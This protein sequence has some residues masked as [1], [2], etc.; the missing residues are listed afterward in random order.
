MSKE[1]L[2]CLRV[3]FPP[4]HYEDSRIA[5]VVDF[6][7]KY[8]YKNVMLFIN[9]EEYH[10]G[11]MT[12]EEAK[13]WLATMK[14]AKAA[15][16]A[17][18]ISV[19]LNPWIELGHL[20][21]CR[22]LKEGQ[23]FVT[24]MDYDG[25]QATMVACPMCENWKKYFFEFYQYIIRELEP[26]VV[27]VEDDF[28]LHNHGSLRFGGCFCPL[29][30]KKYN[31]RLGT[32]YTREEFTDKLFRKECNQKVKKA[33]LDVNRECMRGLAQE[34]GDMVRGLGLHTKIGLMSSAHDNHA[35]EGRDW[36]G[37][38]KAFEVDGVMINR[39]HLP[40][41]DEI[42]SKTYYLNFN[43]VPFHLRALLPAKTT[44]YPELENAAFSTFAKEA[45]FLQFQLESAIPLCIKGM[46]YD[47]FD[48]VG[49][50]AINEFGYGEVVQGI[51]PYLNGVTN[52]H[53]QFNTLEGVQ[54]PIYEN[55]AYNRKCK[56]GFY[57]L[58]PEESHFNAYISSLG[59]TSKPTTKKL[60]KG[61]IVALGGGNVYN[62]TEKQ[63]EKL[64]KDNYVLVDGGAARILIDRGLGY[65]IGANG[66]ETYYHEQTLLSYEQ[67]KEGILINGKPGY[68]A[69]AFA[70]ASDYVRISYASEE[71]AQSFLYDCTGNKM[72]VGMMEG[73]R[74]FV[75]P[76]VVDGFYIEQ[77]HDLRTTLLR[78][79]IRKCSATVVMTNHAG[80][81]AYLYQQKNKKILIVVNSTVEDFKTTNLEM[82]NLEF[83]KIYEINRKTG[84][85]KAVKF[86]KT[87][88]GV[89]IQRE[90][91]HL[92]TQTFILT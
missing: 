53:L 72:G 71:G 46:T 35:L 2:H 87:E 12:I 55:T 56:A 32:K 36:H 92:T 73:E 65:L 41:Y 74:Y 18:G 76:Y 24:Q 48:F 42:S 49:N 40:C 84:R 17:K 85:R 8:G 16:T 52:L 62:F 25:N 20:D 82:Q 9:A 91:V 68:R 7:V 59:I 70:K 54:L 78:N 6:C 19:S 67:V 27:W 38:H 37:I 21:R 14:K 90:N 51:T 50:G 44:I 34:I 88:N 60:F 64:F 47:I 43:R 28:R 58:Y 83:S 23:N 39:L 57:N 31:E 69:S 22:T 89:C 10:V 13:P 45:R 1:F 61:K 4:S 81:Y 80:V 63:L 3:Q 26:E 29:H 86:E 30:M 15:L 79:F 5:E 11:H 75:F 77:Y 66:Y 33:W